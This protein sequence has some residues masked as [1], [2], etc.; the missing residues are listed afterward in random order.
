MLF[1]SQLKE[2]PEKYISHYEVS[3]G[4]VLLYFNEVSRDLKYIS[5]NKHFTHLILKDF[6]SFQLIDSEECIRFSAKQKVP[7]GLL[8]PAPALFYDYYEPGLFLFKF[9]IK[10]ASLLNLKVTS[11][12]TSVADRK[13]TV[14]Y[15]APQRSKMVSKLC[16]EDVCQ[17]AER[18]PIFYLINVPLQMHFSRPSLFK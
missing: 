15:S 4:R 11:I 3:Y 6:F 17:C 9:S 12:C 14:F 5:I 16:S 18:K 7:I 1:S 10:R 2:S 8:Q 13:C